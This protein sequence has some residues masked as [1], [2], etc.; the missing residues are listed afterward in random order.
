MSYPSIKQQID[1]FVSIKNDINYKPKQPNH[2]K[3][4]EY[5]DIE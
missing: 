3:I 5:K 2:E 4:K 1:P